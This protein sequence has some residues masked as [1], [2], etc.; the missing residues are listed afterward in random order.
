MCLCVRVLWG[1]VLCDTG[2]AGVERAAML[3]AYAEAMK[4]YLWGVNNEVYGTIGN[5][6]TTFEVS[7]HLLTPDPSRHPPPHFRKKRASPFFKKKKE[8][9]KMLGNGC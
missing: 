8:K 7:P 1:V 9:K 4:D 2:R 3:Q 6:R 5:R